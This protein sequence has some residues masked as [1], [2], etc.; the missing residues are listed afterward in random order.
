MLGEKGTEQFRIETRLNGEKV[1]D[2]AIHD[3]FIFSRITIGWQDLLKCLLFRRKAVV[4]VRLTGTEGAQR[5]IMMLDPAELQHE[6]EVI[7][8]QR[9]QSR[10]Q[11]HSENTVGYE[12]GD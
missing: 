1:G 12:V 2:Q 7:L 9:A 10:S 3:P 6:T 5:R 11:S 4:E 8:E